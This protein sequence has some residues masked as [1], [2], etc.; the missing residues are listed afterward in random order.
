MSAAVFSLS[1]CDPAAGAEDRLEPPSA[2]S[3]A[4]AFVD[5][6]GALG[7]GMFPVPPPEVPVVE[8][9]PPIAAAEPPPVEPADD[10][11]PE[12]GLAGLVLLSLS[13]MEFP[14][15]CR[16]RDVV[17]CGRIGAGGQA[18][19]LITASTTTTTPMM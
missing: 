7:S 1:A 2:V 3:F 4:G 14:S 5:V 15:R 10:D 17:G 11:A 8:V 16:W 12:V 6:A 18:R 19:K 9:E 13:V